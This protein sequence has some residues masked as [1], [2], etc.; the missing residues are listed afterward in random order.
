MRLWRL[1]DSRLPAAV[2]VAEIAADPVLSAECRDVAGTL[3]DLAAPCGDAFVKRALQPL[4]LV[5][6]VGEAARSSAYWT[7]YVKALR[8]LPAQ[9]LA[10]AVEDYARRPDAAFFPKP[11]PLRALA[12]THAVPIR[13]AATRAR[14]VAALPLP[15]R[16]PPES[17]EDRRRTAAAIRR[18]LT[19]DPA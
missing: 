3:A 2:E 4:V 6:G 1:L 7:V 12:E 18:S 8:D 13:R 19:G 9:A 5:F 11:G 10:R 15:A 17:L 14:A 16:A